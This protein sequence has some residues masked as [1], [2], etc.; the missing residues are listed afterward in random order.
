[1]AHMKRYSIPKVWPLSVKG[2]VWVG[3]PMPGPHAK[4]KCITLGILIRDVLK[5]TENMKET[6][7]VLNDDKVLVN[8]EKRKEFNFPVGLM[9]VIEISETNDYFRMNIN[10]N[11]LFLEKIK[12]E[13]ADKKLCRIV[14]KNIV[15]NGKCQLNLHDGRN[16]LVNDAKKYK[17]CDSVLIELPKQ[18]LLKHF[19]LDK[20]ANVLIIGGKN[21]GL[22]GK[23]KDIKER[24]TIQEKASIIIDVK[25]KD[26]ETLKNYVMV[27]VSE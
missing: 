21:K 26:I 14:N 15:K 17:T 16:L 1:M 5:Y 2:K 11:G 18:K 13:D 27:G 4:E 3:K 22:S 20:N 12:K 25:G 10:R 23:I 9:D 7:K 6:K 8:K 19:K 24:K